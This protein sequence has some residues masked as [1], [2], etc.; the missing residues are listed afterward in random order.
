MATASDVI[1]AFALG[2]PREAF[3]VQ[4][5]AR[6]TGI[7]QHEIRVAAREL[8]ASGRLAVRR[9]R[10]NRCRRPLTVLSAPPGAAPEMPDAGCAAG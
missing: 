1:V 6:K 10:C 2:F 3:C 4:C 9:A 7:A 8:T 5:L